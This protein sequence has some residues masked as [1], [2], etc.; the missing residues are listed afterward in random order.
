MGGR[1]R[2]VLADADDPPT[3]LHNPGILA[4]T[5]RIT[6]NRSGTNDMTVSTYLRYEGDAGVSG[7][8]SFSYPADGNA[9][10]AAA[11][12]L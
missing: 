10:G 11:T 12:R 4:N 5:L 2:Q 8:V 7:K 1:S 3:K 6:G 9:G